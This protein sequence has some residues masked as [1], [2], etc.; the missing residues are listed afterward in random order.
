ML[1]YNEFRKVF[2]WLTLVKILRK[3]ITE[4]WIGIIIDLVTW[5]NDVEAI[6]ADAQD[7]EAEH[8]NL[9]YAD[10]IHADAV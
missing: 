6:Y 8:A 7:A 3:L 2:C 9:E 4:N 10:A 5:K 1:K